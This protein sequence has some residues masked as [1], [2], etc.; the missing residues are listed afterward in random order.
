MK[1]EK[2][3]ITEHRDGTEYEFI[4]PKCKK[5]ISIF[6]WESKVCGCGLHWK[7]KHTIVA[8]GE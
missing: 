4:C 6:I 8:I 2:V 3:Y 7:I 5:Q 1:V